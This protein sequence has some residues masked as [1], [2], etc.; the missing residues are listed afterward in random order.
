MELECGKVRIAF[1]RVFV[2]ETN[3]STARSEDRNRCFADSIKGF[4][5]MNQGC[6]MRRCCIPYSEP[7]REETEDVERSLGG[8]KAWTSL[9]CG[10][11]VNMPPTSQQAQPRLNQHAT[12]IPSM[13]FERSREERRLGY[14]HDFSRSTLAIL[15]IQTGQAKIGD[16]VEMRCRGPDGPARTQNGFIARIGHAQPTRRPVSCLFDTCRLPRFIS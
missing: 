15:T 6:W 9:Q 5:D 2:A 11:L 8:S 4:T 7:C 14:G 12:F 16:G 10:F 13:P 3:M 1:V